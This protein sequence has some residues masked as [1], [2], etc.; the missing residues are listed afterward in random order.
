MSVLSSRGA[1]TGSGPK[2][3]PDHQPERL[4]ELDM[5]G[6]TAPPGTDV[7]LAQRRGSVLI[8][9][10]NRPDRLNAWNEALEQR[11]YALLD[12]ADL[13]PEVRAVV[14]TGAGRGFCSGVDMDDLSGLVKCGDFSTWCVVTHLAAARCCSASRLSQQSA[15]QLPA[16]SSRRCTATFAPPP[17]RQSSPP[18]SPAV[19]LSASTASPGCCRASWA[20]AAQWTSCSPHGSSSARRLFSWGWSTGSSHP[21][22]CST[23]VP[24]LS[25]RLPSQA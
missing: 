24:P 11:Y 4:R 1:P 18:R 10:L 6:T 21:S 13:D 23:E 17:R 7:V 9:A 15:A 22:C 12:Q 8:L 3:A 20:G 25:R 5:T 16:F 2:P 19:A 14:V